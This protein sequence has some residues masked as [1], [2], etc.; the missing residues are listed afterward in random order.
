MYYGKK[1][2]YRKLFDEIDIVA[3]A[4]NALGVKKGEIVTLT[5][6]TLPETVYLFFALNKLGAVANSI[7]PRTNKERLR[8]YIK[9]TN[10]K[11]VFT[12]DKYSQVFS[13]AINGTDIKQGVIT[14]AKN[15]LPS[16]KKI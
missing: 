6:L 10:S 5:V 8:N 4:F 2:T 3:R 13:K 9:N 12:I 15:S 14:S 1:I 11:L 7:D 16:S